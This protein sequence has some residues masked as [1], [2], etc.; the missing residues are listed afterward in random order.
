MNCRNT[1][2]TGYQREAQPARSAYFA[3]PANAALAG[4][5][6]GLRATTVR[7]LTVERMTGAFSGRQAG[8][9]DR[10]CQVR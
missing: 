1:T 10:A 9:Y 8:T 5:A 3:A 6:Y 2:G 4:S 7:A